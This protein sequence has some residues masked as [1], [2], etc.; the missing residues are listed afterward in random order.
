MTG[1]MVSAPDPAMRLG[2]YQG[3]ETIGC[4]VTLA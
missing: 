4:S 1:T 2:R 3:T